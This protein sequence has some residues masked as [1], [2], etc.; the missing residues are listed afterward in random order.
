MTSS[1]GTEAVS[2]HAVKV[3]TELLCCPRCRCQLRLALVLDRPP[4]HPQAQKTISLWT[5]PVSD[6]ARIII[7]KESL[8]IV[9]LQVSERRLMVDSTGRCN[10]T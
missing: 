2:D 6:S 4:D 10:T 1:N 9:T 8:P 5:A 7:D 3:D